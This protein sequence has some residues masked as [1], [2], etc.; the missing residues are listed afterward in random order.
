MKETRLFFIVDSAET[1][2]EIFETLEQ[3][4]TYK[5]TLEKQ[6]KENG[7]IKVAIVK[8]AYKERIQGKQVW[9]YD[10]YS[11]TFEIIKTL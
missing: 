2:Y 5:E 9:K 7:S 1:N 6:N 10:D 11:D 4:E 3:A 8:N